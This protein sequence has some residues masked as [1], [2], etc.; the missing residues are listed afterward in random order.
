MTKFYYI[1]S[2]GF[3]ALSLMIDLPL[4]LVLIGSIV[5]WLF[6]CS[7]VFDKDSFDTEEISKLYSSEDEN[8]KQEIAFILLQVS[9]FIFFVT[10]VYYFLTYSHD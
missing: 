1:G 10:D 5:L 4:T 9:S 3:I 6:V 7:Q 2:I 8:L